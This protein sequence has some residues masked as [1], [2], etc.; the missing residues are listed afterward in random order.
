M[1][2]LLLFLVAVNVSHSLMAFFDGA[3]GYGLGLLGGS[4]AW[5]LLAKA[6]WD[7]GKRRTNETF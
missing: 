5:G 6:Y 2:Y 4:G 3:I 7:Y 1:K